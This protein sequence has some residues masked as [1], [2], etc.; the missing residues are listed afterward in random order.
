MRAALGK[1]CH[2]LLVHGGHGPV[3]DAAGTSITEIGE[4]AEAVDGAA[5][6]GECG[7]GG[8]SSTRE[9]ER[10]AALGRRDLVRITGSGPVAEGTLAGQVA[11]Q[12]SQ[13]PYLIVQ[14]LAESGARLDL[15]RKRELVGDGV[16]PVGHVVQQH[17]LVGIGQRRCSHR[18]VRF[19]RRAAGCLAPGG[20]PK[21]G[22]AVRSGTDGVGA[23]CRK[24]T[25]MPWAV[26]CRTALCSSRARASVL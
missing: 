5:Q 2:E 26:S 12:P 25:P 3:A 1:V 10:G 19:Y 6:S 15:V 13:V 14:D 22:A 7:S 23:A 21:A 8:L 20:A 9:G 4:N 17:P 16:D 24:L 11:Q 18:E